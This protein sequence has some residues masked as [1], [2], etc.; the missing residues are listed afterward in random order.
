ME[1][2]EGTGVLC[3][4]QTLKGSLQTHTTT[5][6]I[7]NTTIVSNPQRISTNRG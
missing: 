7:H 2:R 3:E 1:T 5:T 4:F 6:H